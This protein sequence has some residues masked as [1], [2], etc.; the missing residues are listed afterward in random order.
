M[1]QAQLLLTLHGDGIA[2]LWGFT[3]NIFLHF[4]ILQF[5]LYFKDITEINYKSSSK[6][7]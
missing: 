5:T 3:K 4:I 6:E 2:R 7:L 1:L